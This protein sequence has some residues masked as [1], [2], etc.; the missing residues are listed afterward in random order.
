MSLARV[1]AETTSREFLRWQ[2]FFRKQWYRREKQ[3]YYLA[4][5]ACQVRRVLMQDPNQVST[6]DF[7]VKFE[8]TKKKSKPSLTIT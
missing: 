8:E 3:D 4:Q 2:L 5:I 6:E 1:K 7:I